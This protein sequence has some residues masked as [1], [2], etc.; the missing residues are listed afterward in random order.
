MTKSRKTASKATG[1]SLPLRYRFIAW[2][3][4]TVYFGRIDV[5][6]PSSPAKG[7]RLVVSSHRN[8]AIDG[9][10]VLRAFPRAQFLVSVQLLRSRPLRWMFAGIAV[11]RDKDRERYGIQR[12]AFADPIDA[13]CAHLRAGG[14]LVVFPEG[15]SEWGHQPLPYQR[16][17][18]R[19]ACRLLEEG[20]AVTI[21]PV[22]LHYAQPDRFRSHVEI[23][24]GPQIVLPA[25]ESSE[26]PRAWENRVHEAIGH[27]LDAVSVH[28]RDEA[29]F[30]AAQAWARCSLAA[31][32][33][34]AEAL[35][36]AQAERD[37][38]PPPAPPSRRVIHWLWDGLPLA[39]LFLGCLPIVLAAWYAGSKA[40]GRNTV[41]FLRM[42]GG[43][44]SGFVWLPLA[45]TLAIWQPPIALALAVLAA[46]G[47]WRY[48]R[49]FSQE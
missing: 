40:D 9:Y 15:S 12:S 25:R 24:R 26:S 2:L 33:R 35:L 29:R 45:L 7:A 37:L 18:A 48:P 13:G 38:A 1:A 21:L 41:T 11:V 4:R 10:I 32:G 31:G 44:F 16:G 20:V 28:C 8:G 27:G 5:H 17:A 30:I 36:A 47:W 22:G 42:A 23:V 39:S 43:F 34:Y 6:G 14:D 3:L 19:M 49:M 46:I